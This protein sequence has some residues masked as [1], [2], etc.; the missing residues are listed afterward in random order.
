MLQFIAIGIC[1]ARWIKN[2]T[3]SDRNNAKSDSINIKALNRMEESQMLMREQQN[4]TEMSLE[5][6]ANRKKGILIT[7]IKEFIEIYEKIK[8]IDFKDIGGVDEL[9]LST[10]ASGLLTEMR[11]MSTGAGVSMST[12]QLISTFIIKGGISGIMAKESEMNITSAQIRRKQAAVVTSQSETVK[13]TMDAIYQRAERMSQLLA[14]L[15]ILFRKSIETTKTIIDEKGKNYIN[16]SKKDKEYI[17]TC[18]NF[19]TSIKKIIDTPL[20]DEDG[21]ILKMSIEAIDTGEKYLDKINNV[22]NG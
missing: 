10:I 5:K 13:V 21:K 11:N 18:M 7:S 19:A 8:K 14:K 6:L 16:Y 15:N 12:G 3:D 22:I 17:M 4:K 20:L 1:G 9:S 2:M